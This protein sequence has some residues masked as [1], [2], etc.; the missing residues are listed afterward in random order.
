MVR[1]I[2]GTLIDIGMGRLDSDAFARALHSGNRLDLGVTAP[3]CGLE[4]S[5]ISY[6]NL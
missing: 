5:Q 6:P 2:A 4:L 1:I 3:A